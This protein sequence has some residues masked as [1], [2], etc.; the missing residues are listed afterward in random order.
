MERL[1]SLL[2]ALVSISG[3]SA[4]KLV[5]WGSVLRQSGVPEDILSPLKAD[6]LLK[7]TSTID[8][9]KRKMEEAMAQSDYLMIFDNAIL[10][11]PSTDEYNFKQMLASNQMQAAQNWNAQQLGAQ[12]QQVAAQQQFGNPVKVD[13]QKALRNERALSL[14]TMRLGGVKNAL[15]LGTDDFLVCHTTLDTV[16]VFFVL[17]GREGNTKEEI[18]IFPSDKL[19]TQLRLIMS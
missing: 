4:V 12:Q 17:N 7:I 18:D 10:G 5:D 19:L 2:K 1:I 3:T 15:R 16:Y 11:L 8:S 14:L 13:T 9:A 6:E